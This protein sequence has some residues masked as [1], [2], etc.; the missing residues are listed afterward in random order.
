MKK[1]FKTV[2][3]FPTLP[4]EVSP[5]LGGW[6]VSGLQSGERMSMANI[7]VSLQSLDRP[8]SDKSVISGED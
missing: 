3:T 4:S 6:S 8:G 1:T 2:S 7:R 5:C